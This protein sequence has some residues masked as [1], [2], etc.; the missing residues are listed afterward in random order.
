MSTCSFYR[1]QFWKAFP[2]FFHRW[3]LCS[4]YNF[5]LLWPITALSPKRKT[6]RGNYTL[7]AGSRRRGRFFFSNFVSCPSLWNQCKSFDLKNNI[8]QAISPLNTFECLVHS[9]AQVLFVPYEN[10][11]KS[12]PYFLRILVILYHCSILIITQS[13]INQTYCNVITF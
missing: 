5:E 13:P 6:K 3:P 10:R 11:S 9:R 1:M 8:K 2:P 12:K 4:R 7:F